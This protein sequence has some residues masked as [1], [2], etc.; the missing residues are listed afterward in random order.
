MSAAVKL[1]TCVYHDYGGCF[2]SADR[3]CR[4][5]LYVRNT[6]RNYTHYCESTRGGTCHSLI[7]PQP[8]I[9][10]VRS[11]AAGSCTMIDFGR[12]QAGVTLKLFGVILLSIGLVTR[13]GAFC[14]CCSSSR[15]FKVTQRELS[16]VSRQQETQCTGKH[17]MRRAEQRQKSN[18]AALSW[19]GFQ[20]AFSGYLQYLGNQI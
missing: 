9:R 3:S 16:R 5:R 1:C 11:T 18:A 4:S 6:I 12:K 2:V 14:S 10:R 17:R 19:W 8:E 20:G 13:V 15:L 7:P